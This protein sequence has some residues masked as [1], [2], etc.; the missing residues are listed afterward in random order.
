MTESPNFGIVC[1]SI[2]YILMFLFAVNM[3]A[4][5]FGLLVN[6]QQANSVAVRPNPW[7]EM[8]SVYISPTQFYVNGKSIDRKE[9]QSK[10]LEA[11]NKQMVWTVYFEA[12]EDCT[13]EEAAYAM[14]TIQGLGAK[15][16]WITPKM[17]EA[18]AENAKH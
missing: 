15:V 4:P 10:L 7:A 13:F 8:T 16:V 9:L 14:D 5:S 3:P 12:H 6:L 18:L 17:R 11:L 2:L 1:G